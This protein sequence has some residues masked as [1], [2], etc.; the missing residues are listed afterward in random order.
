MRYRNGSTA[1]HFARHY[2]EMVIAMFLGMALLAL[3]VRLALSAAGTSWS[4]LG[5]EAMFLGMAVEMTVP[6]VAWMRYR[7]H[8]RRANGE[9][10]AAMLLPTF[11]AI[12]LLRADVAGS[13][14]LMLAEH[15]A[16]LLSMLGV[17]LMRP[18][19]YTHGHARAE[20]VAA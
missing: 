16:M 4:E 14:A 2:V 10:A 5:H 11:A 17:M 20:A 13:G 15:V 1:W 8:G 12:A 18:A 19:E 3:P 7:G 6:M 9:M